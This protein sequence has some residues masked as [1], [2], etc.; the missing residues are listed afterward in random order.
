MPVSKIQKKRVSDQVFDQMKELIA[1]QKW[2]IGAKIPSEP[3]LMKMFGVSRIS[4]REAIKQLVCLGLLETRQGS[5]TYVRSYRESALA[6][7]FSAILSKQDLLELLEMRRAIEI[8]SA[9]LAAR[10][11]TEE[12]IDELRGLCAQME[13]DDLPPEMNS[14]LDLR[15]HL[16]IA[17]STKNKYI[18]ETTEVIGEPLLRFFDTTVFLNFSK[19]NGLQRHKHILSAIEHHNVQEARLIMELH[20]D[21]TIKVAIEGYE[22]RE[23]L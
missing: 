22:D 12:E 21:D 18:I 3:Q 11:A 13:R 19:D 4:I 14:R 10:R 8:E 16:A 20:L 1:G 2:E 23:G 15:F 6:Q 17:R 7:N 9:G 5:G